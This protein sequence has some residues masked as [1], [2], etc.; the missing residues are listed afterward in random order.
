MRRRDLGAVTAG[1]VLA[2]LGVAA[3]A[4][5]AASFAAMLKWLWPLVLIGLGVALLATR[6][7]GNGHVNGRRRA[8][9]GQD[10]P[11]DEVGAERGEDG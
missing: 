5:G 11:G 1:L 4:M 7:S 8:S 2:G 10:R 9:A 3:L 6:P